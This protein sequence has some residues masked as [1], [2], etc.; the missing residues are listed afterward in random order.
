MSALFVCP[1]FQLA[2]LE[3]NRKV[4]EMS[5]AEYKCHSAQK[6]WKK[7]ELPSQVLQL[8]P[9][10]SVSL[11]FESYKMKSQLKSE[12]F[13]HLNVSKGLELGFG[14]WSCQGL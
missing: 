10:S 5:H 6:K 13:K 12:M 3:V 11:Y 4:K 8:V 9:N 2:P 7:K 14:N 1:Y